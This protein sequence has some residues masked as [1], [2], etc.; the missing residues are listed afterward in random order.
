MKPIG[1][2]IVITKINEEK[3]TDSGLILS[4]DDV[5]AYRYHRNKC[6]KY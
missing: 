3:K 4:A 1:K 6:G 2:Y 5:N